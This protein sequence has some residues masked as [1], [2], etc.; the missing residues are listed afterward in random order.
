MW[1]WQ[2]VLNLQIKQWNS[3]QGLGSL[4][5]SRRFWRVLEWQIKQWDKACL[6]IEHVMNINKDWIKTTSGHDF[7]NG[8]LS[9][10]FVP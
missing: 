7:K 4:E 3:L 10:R 5:G 2:K 1:L 8:F 9:K 6:D